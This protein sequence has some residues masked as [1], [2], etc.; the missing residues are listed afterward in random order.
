M[1]IMADKT[2]KIAYLYE[3]LMNTYGDSGDVKVIRYL[4][5]KQGYQTEVDNISLDDKFDA[6]DYDFIL[7]RRSRL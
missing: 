3:D 2:I 1:I 6:N 4:L 5:D 7:W